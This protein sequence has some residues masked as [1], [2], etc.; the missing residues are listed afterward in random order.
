MST[1]GRVAVYTGSSPG[2]SP[3]YRAAAEAVGTHLAR[4]GVGIVYGGGHVGLMGAVAD[5]ALDAGGDVAGVIPQA[6]VDAELAHPRLTTLEVVPDMHAR[7]LRMSELADAFVALPGGPGTLEELF[8]SWTWLQLG[9]HAKP[10]A[11]YD[12]D[13]FWAPLL[14]MLDGMVGAGFVRAE[15]R[16]TLIV[17]RTPEELLSAFAAWQPPAPKFAR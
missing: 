12:V 7:K 11:I 13:G 1:V 10:V 3:A 4:E 15:F 17:V 9:F 16:D 6:L 2:L 14:A 5:A 8:E